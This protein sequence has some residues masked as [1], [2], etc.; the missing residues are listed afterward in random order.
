[1]QMLLFTLQ[2]RP[3]TNMCYRNVLTKL[4]FLKTDRYRKL[5]IAYAKRYIKNFIISID[6]NNKIHLS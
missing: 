2:S 6:N 3:C 5:D 1:M 4:S